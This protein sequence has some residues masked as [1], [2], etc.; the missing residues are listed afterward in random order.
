MYILWARGNATVDLGN[1]PK[2]FT[3]DNEHNHHR[4]I[5]KTEGLHKLQLLRADKIEITE[6]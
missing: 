5:S 1:T 4:Q 2:K 3:V 6:K